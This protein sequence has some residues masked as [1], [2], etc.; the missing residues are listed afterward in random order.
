MLMWFVVKLVYSTDNYIEPS[1]R[2]CKFLIF[3]RVKICFYDFTKVRRK[4][5]TVRPAVVMSCKYNNSR[6]TTLIGLVPT[7][8]VGVLN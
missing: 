7:L 8:E 4:A 5:E 6:M 2:G 3:G 1:C